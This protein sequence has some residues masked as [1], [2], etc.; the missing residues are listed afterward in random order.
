VCIYVY[1]YTYTYIY[2]YIYIYKYIYR[3]F[4]IAT[5]CDFC[6]TPY[7]KL[8]KLINTIHEPYTPYF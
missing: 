8:E 2:I 6:Y 7:F 4:V 5:P 3:K 1:I